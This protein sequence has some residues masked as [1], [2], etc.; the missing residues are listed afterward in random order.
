MKKLLS[1]FGGLF[2]VLSFLGI[3]GA[4]TFTLDNFNVVLNNTDP[5]LVLQSAP[6]QTT[7]FSFDLNVGDSKTFDLF[8][9]WTNETTVNDDDKVDKSINV[10]MNFTSPP[11]TF[12]SS[13]GGETTGGYN[14]KWYFNQQFGRVEWDGPVTFNFGNNGTGELIISLSNETFNWG[15]YGL[16]SGYCHGANVEATVTYAKA[17]VPEP[18][19]LLLLGS[20]LI[21]VAALRRRIKK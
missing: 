2:L 19:I 15:L 13:I 9:I 18:S 17:P 6:V 3:A 21:G 16:S 12:G 4:T 7:T 8:A 1:L 20:G 10:F 11:P 5:G 14:G